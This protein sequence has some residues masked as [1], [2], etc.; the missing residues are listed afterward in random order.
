MPGI[1]LRAVIAAVAFSLCVL[2]AAAYAVQAAE[3]TDYADDIPGSV[4]PGSPFT[5]DLNETTDPDDVFQLNL[6]AGQNLFVKMT[7]AAGSDFEL[8]VFP[9]NT[10]SVMGTTPASVYSETPGTSSERIV[11]R[12]VPVSGR[13]YLDAWAFA[14]SGAYTITYG[15]PTVQPTLASSAKSSV[16]WG[17]TAVVNG[18]M[19]APGDVPVIGETVYLYGKGYRQSSFVKVGE[20]KTDAT[21]AYS[22]SVKPTSGTRYR[23]RFF[24][25]PTYLPADAADVQV[26]P[27][28]YLT[29][30]TAP[31][32]TKVGARFTSAGYLKPRHAA[33]SKSVKLSCYR[34]EDNVWRVRKTVYA[35]CSDYSSYTKY[36]ASVTLPYRGRWKIVASVPADALHLTTST[37]ARY[38]TVQ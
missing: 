21:G 5:G 31:S 3:V 8:Y 6:S 33:G 28:A 1:R 16:S 12:G 37:T 29:R 32:T 38:V 17:G 30:P 35:T 20:A 7:G 11:L 19:R 15:F 9:P 26:T 13:Y 4:L 10:A 25:S 23:A 22:F 14:G 24:G 34:L 36:G 27:Y 2:P 18:T